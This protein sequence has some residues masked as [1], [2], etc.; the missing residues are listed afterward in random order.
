MGQGG[1]V[2]P[3]SLAQCKVFSDIDYVERL[4]L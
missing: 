2:F 1:G 4:S 3:Q